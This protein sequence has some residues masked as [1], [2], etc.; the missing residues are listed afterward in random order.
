MASNPYAGLNANSD[1]YTNGDGIG[2]TL[3]GPISV[4]DRNPASSPSSDDYD[5]YGERYGTPPISAASS[6][7]AR[8]RRGARTGGYGGFYANGSGNNGSGTNMNVQAPRRSNE[9]EERRDAYGGTNVGARLR[10]D[11]APPRSQRRPSAANE[12]PVERER[13]LGGRNEAST[14]PPD[15][16]AGRDF[17]R[18]SAGPDRG[19]SNQSNGYNNAQRS[20]RAKPIG[21]SAAAGGGDGTRQIEGQ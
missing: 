13:R 2:A 5:P 17:R 21:I 18:P 19:Y 10:D 14:L 15:F 4:P 11:G 6:V 12:G 7:S 20:E 8:E 9:S 3:A 16:G 1:P